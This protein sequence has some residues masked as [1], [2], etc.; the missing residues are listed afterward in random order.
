MQTIGEAY[1]QPFTQSERATTQAINARSRI[2]LSQMRLVLAKQRLAQ[3][4]QMANIQLQNLAERQREFDQTM[5]LKNKEFDASQAA[6]AGMSMADYRA[7]KA[8]Q[9]GLPYKLPT[10]DGGEGTYKMPT[11]REQGQLEQ[12]VNAWPQMQSLI[13]QI[14]NGA[15]YFLDKPDKFKKYTAAVSAAW[16][17]NVTPEQEKILEDAG[18]SSNAIIQAAETQSRLMNVAKT[19]EVFQNTKSL[20]QPREGETQQSYSARLNAAMLDNARRF[21]QAQ[22]QLQDIP[23]DAA[24]QA[25]QNKKVDQQLLTDPMLS[26]LNGVKPSSV[27]VG[28]KGFTEDQIKKV[29]DATGLSR[30]QAITMLGG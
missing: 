1:M 23:L 7:F 17:G 3:M 22:L 28:N 30:A 26:N 27:S 4:Q 13:T 21:F 8:R 2:Q 24:A 9:A 18:I 19:N 10:S 14:Q 15:K 29:M 20:F 6:P 12:V 11:N 5:A 16:T 25:E